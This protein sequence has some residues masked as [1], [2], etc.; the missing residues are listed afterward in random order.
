MSADTQ[1]DTLQARGLIRLA[2]LQ[3]ELEYLFRHALVQDAAYGSL[4]KQER[5]E[6]HGQVGD[7]LEELYPE[8]V[9]ELAPVLAMHFEQA[10]ENGKAIDYYASGAQHAMDQNAIREAFT[11]YERAA[12]LLS[13]EPPLADGAPDQARRRR[14]QVE[15]QLGRARAGYSF[16]SP[17]EQ[18]DALEKIV[19]DADAVGD[20][21]LVAGVHLL[22]ALGRLQDGEPPE[23]PLVK[24]SLDRISEVAEALGDP[25]LR[26]TPLA[27]IG[28]GQ[29]FAGSSVRA[30][31][32]ALEEAVP[33]L[34][35]G[36]DSIGAAFARGALAIGYA[37]LGDFGKAEAAANRA[38]EIAENG[39]L[40]AQLD[41]LIAESI[42]KSAKG[43]LDRAVPLAQECVDRAEE[44][45]ASACVVASAWILGDAFH[46]QGRFTEAREILKR[47]SDISMVLDR[48]VWRPTLQAWLGSTM[49]SLGE[50]GDGG[51]EEALATARSIGS[52]IG[53]TGILGKR[54]EAAATRG[55]IDAA[56]ADFEASTAIAEELG[57]R[58]ALARGLRTWADALRAAGRLDAAEPH[59]RRAL[60][61]FEELGLEAE[62]SAIR[63]ELALGGVTI[64]F[65]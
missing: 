50:I 51:L 20:L 45:G 41:A 16:L 35:V 7:A 29:I 1:L 59:A 54:A 17:E 34:E 61:L 10:G 30:G 37:S 5:R 19:A 48:R 6:L 8:R 4:L 43:E 2:S 47:G 23:A 27:L 21:R 32:A 12:G 49:A 46:R 24:R 28:L 53:E 18:Y 57:L 63:T 11:A 60:A 36:T 40:I 14:Q 31:V 13:H 26:A 3:P 15:F 52:R 64:A 39:D 33:L 42:V 22:I 38:R 65:D 44:T 62:A 9:G 56:Q 55:D 58:P 25:T